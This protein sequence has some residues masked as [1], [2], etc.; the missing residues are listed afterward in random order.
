MGLFFKLGLAVLD[1]FLN[2][3]AQ[4]KPTRGFFRQ[5]TLLRQTKCSFWIPD[6]N[7]KKCFEIS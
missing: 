2:F 3:R 4:K 1:I 6:P 5:E 7:V